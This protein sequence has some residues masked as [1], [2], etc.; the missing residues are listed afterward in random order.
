MT[1][2]K[3]RQIALRCFSTGEAKPRIEISP[4]YFYQNYYLLLIRLILITIA[5]SCGHSLA[6]AG[7]HVD[8][9]SVAEL[10]STASMTE[11][12]AEVPGSIP[13]LKQIFVRRQYIIS[14]VSLCVNCGIYRYMCQQLGFPSVGQCHMCCML[15]VV[16]FNTTP[17]NNESRSVRPCQSR[18]FSRK[19][20]RREFKLCHTNLNPRLTSFSLVQPR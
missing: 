20:A 15:T 17:T 12:Y 2:S 3:Q 19:G 9:V 10:I 4:A 8:R 1:N 13:E 5:S 18:R 6:R 7:H 16:W 14:L 11:H